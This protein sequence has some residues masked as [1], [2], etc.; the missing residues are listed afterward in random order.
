MEIKRKI[1][2]EKYCIVLT[3]QE[4]NTVHAFYRILEG[5][6]RDVDFQML[7]HKAVEEIMMA[8]DFIENYL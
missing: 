5:I 2:R 3:E 1:L 8:Q 7:P 6:K 4:Q